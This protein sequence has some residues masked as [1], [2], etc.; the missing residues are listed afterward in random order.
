M[1]KNIRII[2]IYLILF[3]LFNN[4]KAN[5]KYDFGEYN[6]PI[7]SSQKGA[8]KDALGIYHNENQEPFTLQEEIFFQAKENNKSLNDSELFDRNFLKNNI[9]QVHETLVNNYNG[10]EVIITTQDNIEINCLYFNRNSD[11]LIVVGAGFT[12]AKELMAPFINMFPNYDIVLFDYRGH[13]IN[14]KDISVWYKPLTK[15]KKYINKAFGVD[16]NITRM[17]SMEDL[18]VTAV[19]EYFKYNN[20]KKYTCVTGLGICY[21][22]L[23]FLQAQALHRTK[24][25]FDKI[26]LDGCWLSLKKFVTKLSQDPKLL[27]SPQFGGLQY[28][29][30]F[31]QKWFQKGF[32]IMAPIV[33]NIDYENSNLNNLLTFIT[34]TPILYFYGKN[35][36]TIDRTDFETIFN[37]LSASENRNAIT[38]IITPIPHVRNH[39]WIKEFYKFACD[40][41]IELDNNAFIKKL[42]G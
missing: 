42:R 10:Q 30:P 27:I 18:D 32:R 11:N 41:F 23:I 31:N 17:A 22:A 5:F 14:Q 6:E 19:V 4:L 36:L 21:S 35:D 26:I 15:V 28:T 12:N 1:L 8:I 3:F 20:N 7:Y 37:G 33:L 16:T 38:A 25:L 34:N 39:L 13:G 2:N 9:F 29:Y 40:N 24:K